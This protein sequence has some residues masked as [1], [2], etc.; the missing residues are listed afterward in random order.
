MEEE[1]CRKAVTWLYPVAHWSCRRIL[2]RSALSLSGKFHA[3][4]WQSSCALSAGHRRSARV[5]TSD[6]ACISSAGVAPE[7]SCSHES[8]ASR[9]YRTVSWCT[10]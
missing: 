2:V 9:R 5:L 7:Q 8:H 10:A 4:E 1:S 6:C 3:A